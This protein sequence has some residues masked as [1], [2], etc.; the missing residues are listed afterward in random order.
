M[1][2]QGKPPVL[3]QTLTTYVSKNGSTVIPA[4]KITE[5]FPALGIALS[6]NH[7]VPATYQLA[8][9]DTVQLAGARVIAG[10]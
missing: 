8:Q 5:S 4:N 9:G 10:D 2:Q 6:D 3:S 1:R 7:F